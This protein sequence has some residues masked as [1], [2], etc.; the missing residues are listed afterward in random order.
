[1]QPL[2]PVRARAQKAG[3]RF[4]RLRFLNHLHGQKPGILPSEWVR[5]GADSRIRVSNSMKAS[6]LRVSAP[7]HAT[8]D[9]AVRA[10][11]PSHE[12]RKPRAESRARSCHKPGFLPNPALSTWDPVVGTVRMASDH[13]VLRCLPPAIASWAWA[14]CQMH[15]PPRGPHARQSRGR[16]RAGHFNLSS[17][18]LKRRL[19]PVCVAMLGDSG[20]CP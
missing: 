2:A 11:T 3:V 15:G 10:F 8:A 6:V 4:Q 5:V 9:V 18:L 7:H 14:I 1:M 16:A 12:G 17:P 13:A 20:P 19:R